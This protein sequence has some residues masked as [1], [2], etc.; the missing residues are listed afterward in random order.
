MTSRTTTNKNRFSEITYQDGARTPAMRQLMRT[1]TGINSVSP[2]SIKGR[3][4]GLDKTKGIEIL[5]AL[6]EE[7]QCDV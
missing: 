2:M 7:D 4:V 6:V 3:A 5:P 1:H